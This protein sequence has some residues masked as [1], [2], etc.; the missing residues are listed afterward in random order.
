M[1]SPGQLRQARASGLTI[2]FVE[3]DRRVERDADRRWAFHD[4][5]VIVESEKPHVADLL[6]RVFHIERGR[7]LPR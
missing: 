2:P 6:D 4:G 1:S 5:A 7:V 3:H